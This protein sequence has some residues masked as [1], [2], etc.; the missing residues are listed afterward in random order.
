MS[1]SSL[2]DAKEQV[3]QA[4]DIVDLV[5][6]YVALRRQGRGFVALCPWHDDSRPSLQVNPER[7]SWKCW[8][9]DVGGDIFSW[10]M[11]SEGLEFR[12]ALEM[13]AERAGVTLQPSA[14]PRSEAES[15]FDRRNLLRAMAWAEEQFHQCLRQSPEA[16]PARRYLAER[17]IE[18]ASIDKF[19]LGFAPQQWDWLLGRA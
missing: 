16:E 18:D 9:C 12:E 2:Q 4:V 8:V 5:G 3:R 17:G 10:V 1:L 13:L 15:Q 11:R 14:A 7:Q 6:G 19:R